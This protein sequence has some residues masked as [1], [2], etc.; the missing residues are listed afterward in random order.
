MFWLAW[1]YNPI[2]DYVYARQQEGKY[3]I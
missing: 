2:M 1:F 3:A